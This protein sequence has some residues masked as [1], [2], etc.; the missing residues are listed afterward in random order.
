MILKFD[1]WPQKPQ[2][3]SSMLRQA[4]CIISKQL[5]NSNWSYSPETP[6]S[7]QNRRFI[8]SRM[9]LKFDRWP[10]KT[11]GLLFYATSS[12]VHHFVA[13]SEF[14]LELQSVNPQCGSKLA[15]FF[16]CDLE[17]WQMTL[18]NNG[19][20]ILIYLKLCAWFCSH[21]CIQTGVTI[22]K[23]PVWVKIDDSC[24]LWPWS[25][26]DDLEKQ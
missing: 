6:N 26:R 21:W 25:L 22:R 17:F 18:K 10:W 9:T 4:L 13:I 19:A 24:P 15:I 5:V 12:F 11:I 8:L 7:A 16:P 2:G 14:K 3:T 1:R 23:R 20:P